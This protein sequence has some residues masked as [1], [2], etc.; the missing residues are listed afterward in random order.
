MKGLKTGGREQGTPNKLTSDLR[1]RI[2]DFL[3]DN[4]EQ[5]EQDFKEIEP[6]KRIAM[7]EKLLQYTLPRLQATQLTM[8]EREMTDDELDR[9]IYRLEAKKTPLTDEERKARI[10]ELKKQLFEDD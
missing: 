5:V 1:E 3:N 7:F 2:S 4:W 6:E 10:A 8:P 9:E